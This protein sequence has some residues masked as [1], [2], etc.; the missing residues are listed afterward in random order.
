MASLGFQYSVG[1]GRDN[2]RKRDC[3]YNL[4][5]LNFRDLKI[6][7]SATEGSTVFF[8][9]LNIL[10]KFNYSKIVGLYK[11][12]EVPK[13]DSHYSEFLD[14]QL[15]KCF[16]FNRWNRNFLKLQLIKQLCHSHCE[17]DI[18]NQ[19]ALKSQFVTRISLD[20]HRNCNSCFKIIPLKVK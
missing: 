12:I 13:T 11:I 15:H 19:Q 17:I 3:M 2:E 20:I 7:L 1:Y 9:W 5:D 18:I 6:F 16:D 10:R 14:V 4:C 8:C